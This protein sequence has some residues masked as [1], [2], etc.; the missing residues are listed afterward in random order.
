MGKTPLRILCFGNSLT[1]GFPADHPYAVKMK[2]KLEAAF[3]SLDVQCEVNGVPGD[4]VTRG[5]FKQRLAT[6]WKAAEH[7]FDWTIVLGGT[8]DIGWGYPAEPIADALKMAWDIS[9]TKGGK[10]LAL[11]IPECKARHRD[12][13]ERRGEVNKAIKE[14]KK[15]NFYTFDLFE[16]IPF[17]KMSFLDREKNWE[18]DGIHF[19]ADGY[20]CMG[21]KIAEALT[22][23]M[24]LEE[25]QS[26]EISTVIADV[27]QRRQI[28]EMILDE[29]MGDPKR[30]S[31]GYIVVRKRD[32]D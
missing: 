19:T 13:D 27:R 4:L 8:N 12:T 22:K 20:D 17:H 29:E 21:E 7:P 5:T 28:E 18:V 24:N 23:I 11:T 2:E 14:Y 31:Q 10:V 9:L 26:T 6:S 32:L 15:Q 30:L 3:P 16:A 25:A 1:S